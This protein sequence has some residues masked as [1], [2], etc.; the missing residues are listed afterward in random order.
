MLDRLGVLILYASMHTADPGSTGTG[1]VT[2]GTYTR[3][4]ITW[5]P[6]SGGVLD[7]SN[8]PV[9]DIPA[10]TTITHAG[11][12]SALTGG[13]FYGADLLV[14]ADEASPAPETF[15]SAGTYTLNDAKL[16]ILD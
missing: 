3:E 10:G 1:E 12:W 9:F 14:A 8:A 11:F 13:T 16:E 7:S 2:G 4:S 5:L 6:A 15:T